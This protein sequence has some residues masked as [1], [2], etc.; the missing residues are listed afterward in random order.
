MAHDI[1]PGEGFFGSAPDLIVKYSTVPTSEPGE[2]DYFRMLHAENYA[3]VICL[4]E[5]VTFTDTLIP[6]G[7]HPQIRCEHGHVTN[8]MPARRFIHK[9]PN[10]APDR[11][12][13][14]SEE[15]EK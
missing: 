13:G 15:V 4:S 1:V 9:P 8:G 12:P 2:F 14:S 10:P 3:C 7:M 6:S 5:T 11:C